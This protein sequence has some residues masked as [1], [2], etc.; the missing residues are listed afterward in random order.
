MK[1][2][3]L[4]NC[5]SVGGMCP[6]VTIGVSRAGKMTMPHPLERSL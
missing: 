3:E 6:L 4:V 2:C 1:A 5:K